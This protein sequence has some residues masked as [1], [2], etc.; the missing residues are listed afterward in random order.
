MRYFDPQCFKI[1]RHERRGS[2]YRDIGSKGPQRLDVGASDS[3]EENISQNHN[4]SAGE[5][6]QTFAHG[7]GVEQ[8]LRRVLMGTVT[9]VDH[10]NVEDLREVLR[11]PGGGVPHHDHIGLQGLDGLGGVAQRFP[12]GRR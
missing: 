7:E 1:R 6:A 9:G 2:D 3:A 5:I 12:L 4:A 11:R 10:G 8:A